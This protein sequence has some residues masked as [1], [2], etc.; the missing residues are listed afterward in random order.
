MN[1][2]NGTHLVG[3]V[4]GTSSPNSLSDY[5]TDITC[6][7]GNTNTPAG[8]TS[9]TTTALGYGAKVTCTIT[10]HRKARLQ[11]VKK[12]DPATD[13]GMFNLQI[14]GVTKKVDATHND[15]TGYVN[16]ANGTHLVGEVNGTS[17]PNSLSDYDTDITCDNGNTNTPAGGTSLTT[18]ALGYGAKV[19]CTITNHR[20][21]R[22]QVVKKLDPATDNGMFNLQI[23]GVTKKVDATHN[24]TTG[25]VNV[26]NGTHLVGEV[27]GT[28]SP[29]SLSDYDT[30]IT[31]DNGN[32]NT[33]A[34]GTSLTTTALGYGAKVTCTITNHRKARLQ[35]VKKL[36]PAT[37]NG[38]FNLQIDGVTKKVDATHN[39]TTGYVNVANGT[40]LVGEVNGTSSP[41]S[42]SDYDTDITCDNGNTNTPAGGTS[43]TTTALGYGAKV[44]CTITNTRKATITGLKYEDD[45]ANGSNAADPA[46]AP[47]SGWT[48]RAYL[49]ANGSGTVDAGDSVADSDVTAADGTYTLSVSA[50][51]KYVVCELVSD[52]TGWFQ[53]APPANTV[54]AGG[55]GVG[56]RGYVLGT[57]SP[58]QNVTG[59]DFG[60]FRQGTVT[61]RKFEDGNSNGTQDGTEGG[62]TGWTIKAY[63]DEDGNGSVDTSE[64][65]VAAT[66]A[67]NAS[68]SYTLTLD[69]GAYVICEVAQSNWLQTKPNP[70][71][72]T[73]CQNATGAARGGYAV[74]V[75]SGSSAGDKDFGN[76]RFG[77]TSTMTD[78]A[79]QLKDD[80]T[81]WTITD[82]EIL[83]NSQNTI[84][85]TNPGQFYYHQR[86]TNTSGAT[87]SMAFVVNWP[88]QFMTQ[89]QG[90]Q[91]IHAYLQ[92]PTDGPN[93]WRDWTPQSSG[94]SWTNTNTA[95]GCVKTSSAGPV[96]TGTIT[97]NNVPAG[98]KVWVTVHLDYAWKS[99]GGLS[100]SFGNPPI[101][102]SP[103]TSTATMVGGS[104][105]SNAS[106][107]GR[108]KKVTVVYGTLVDSSG[109]SLDNV[110][111]KLTQGS[112]TATAQTG[113]DG[114][115]V[116]YDGQ[117]CTVADG[118]DGG[119]TGAS[120]STW[121]FGNGNVSSKLE[122]LGD[123]ASAAAAA[124]YP[125][126]KTNAAVK[127]GSQTFATFA[128]PVLPT[129]TFSV[130]KN[131][132]SNRDW[133]FGP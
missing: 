116:F 112:N 107:L 58:A 77:S 47:L 62:L 124:T 88:C 53:S 127:S 6:D 37:D 10:N 52:H 103:F 36:D 33:P 16:V 119:C 38:M 25:Y 50:G 96:G 21:A 1:V 133:R 56:A 40:H 28:S 108:G 64:T 29:N 113:S 11:V 15:T 101:V 49:D 132:A 45:N 54:C 110:W 39:D 20:K 23:D 89:T 68:G 123:G 111:V 63:K 13:N 71:P 60:N 18:T 69:P 30:D 115:Y 109:N 128:A 99:T 55:V 2:A 7:N 31:C 70:G 93:V 122:I 14:D 100:S 86:V 84:V 26:A 130:A 57:L 41:N 82:F 90:G 105:T 129:Y 34:G 94:I 73:L 61:G 35:V 51:K 97:A 131:S 125:T 32:T 74:V 27:N 95:A 48:I 17:S 121:T 98:A 87:G 22:L 102:Y 43:L 42:L 80:L 67:T 65:T 81:P 83:I 72:N 8:G 9:L 76:A 120:T 118:L 92:L 66:S 106:L 114:T 59:K 79:F 117:G 75:T 4:N 91:P 44:T 19:T 12:L 3:E 104:S 85:A 24:D 46:D 126:A 5:D 78:S